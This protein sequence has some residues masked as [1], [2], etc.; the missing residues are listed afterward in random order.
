VEKCKW[1]NTGDYEFVTSCKNEFYGRGLYDLEDEL[2]Y[3]LFK[4]CPY[5]GKIRG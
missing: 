4:Y 3:L 5:C 1:E 2:D